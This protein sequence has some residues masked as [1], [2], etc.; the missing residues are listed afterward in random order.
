MYYCV[1]K[2]YKKIYKTAVNTKKWPKRLTEIEG[3][4]VDRSSSAF[5]IVFYFFCFFLSFLLYHFFCCIKIASICTK[6]LI[7]TTIY[8]YDMER[9]ETKIN[10]KL[11]Y[12]YILH[13]YTKYDIYILYIAF[14]E[15]GFVVVR[16]CLSPPYVTLTI[17]SYI[18][19]L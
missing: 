18:P 16:T 5:L 8:M 3:I 12:T 9:K 17:A 15:H 7:F 11:I 10:A 13:I 2:V 1:C 14:S 19:A 6:D 4:M